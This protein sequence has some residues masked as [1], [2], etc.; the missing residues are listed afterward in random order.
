MKSATPNFS[1]CSNAENP[2]D[3]ISK[4]LKMLDLIG[5]I[6]FLFLSWVQIDLKRKKV[7]TR[8]LKRICAVSAADLNVHNVQLLVLI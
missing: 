4:K 2:K 8:G 6:V 7:K 1:S 3:K 5:G